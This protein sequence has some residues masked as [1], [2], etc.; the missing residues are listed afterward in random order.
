MDVTI[1]NW[2]Q[3]DFNLTVWGNFFILSKF[4]ISFFILMKTILK[5]KCEAISLS[6]KAWL[7][8]GYAEG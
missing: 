6:A 1:R 3:T 4:L 7:K 8:L 5:V 2:S